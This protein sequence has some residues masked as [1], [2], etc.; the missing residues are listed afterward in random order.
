MHISHLT[1]ANI[2]NNEKEV[3]GQLRDSNF[4]DFEDINLTNSY[5]L[6]EKLKVNSFISP[7]NK[8]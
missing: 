5:L 8:F 7:Q 2:M 6:K 1:S 3:I 4:N